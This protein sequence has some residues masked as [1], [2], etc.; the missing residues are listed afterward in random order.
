MA[1]QMELKK[2][3]WPPGLLERKKQQQQ[4][5]V[6]FTL[7]LMFRLTWTTE[8]ELGR[9]ISLKDKHENFI[10]A[11]RKLINVS[12]QV[13]MSGSEK[14]IAIMNTGNKIFGNTYDN[15]SIKIMCNQYVLRFSRTIR[16]C[17]R[18]KQ[19]QRKTK[20]RAARAN[21]FFR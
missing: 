15:S 9:R 20:N 21:L 18:E 10:A 5:R 4:S 14:V 1:T 12:G 6:F 13:K 11:V 16:H 7:F 19:R 2:I 17:S 8:K 3:A